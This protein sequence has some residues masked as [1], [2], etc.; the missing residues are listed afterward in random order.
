MDS[1]L[2]Y[3]RANHDIRVSNV[4]VIDAMGVQVGI[5]PLSE[6]LRMAQAQ[7]LDLVEIAPQANP[8]V[9]K[10][11]DYAKFKYDQ[12]RKWKDTHKKQ[13]TSELKEVRFRPSVHEHD[14]STKIKHIEEF[15]GEHDKVRVTVFFR[16]REITHQ[17]I[18]ARLMDSI[19]ERLKN[20]AKVDK[21]PALDGKRLIMVLSPK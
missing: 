4:R 10:I 18:G 19:K 20:K 7:G 8:P 16:G 2:P 5:R 9:C 11:I 14:L 6:A 17:E 13:K 15:L 1:R 21:E 3:W 12:L